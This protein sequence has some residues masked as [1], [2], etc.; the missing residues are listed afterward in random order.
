MQLC[1]TVVVAVSPLLVE[2][3]SAPPLAVP[4]SVVSLTVLSAMFPVVCSCVSDV[5]VVESVRSCPA[6]SLRERGLAEASSGRDANRAAMLSA[7]SR[8][9]C[10]SISVYSRGCR[11]TVEC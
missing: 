2:Q 10:S 7:R 11:W 6:G 4:W 8:Y 9:L 3:L 1:L 5:S